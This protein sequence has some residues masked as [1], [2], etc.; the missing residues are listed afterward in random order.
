MLATA[1]DT[2]D[3]A[4]DLGRAGKRDERGHRVLDKGVTD[5]GTG[6][7]HHAQRPGWQA[8]LFEDARQQQA[9]ADRGVAGRLDHHGIAQGQGRCQGTG[10]QVQGEVPRADHPDHPQWLA[11]HPAFL[12]GNVG[13]DNAPVDAAGQ[14]CRLQGDG[15]GG[16]PFD[17]GLDPGAAG[18]ADDPVDDFLTTFIEDAHGLEHHLAACG[19]GLCGPVRLDLAGAAVRRIEVVAVGHGNLQ[20]GLLVER[21][22]YRQRALG[23]ASTPV[24]GQRLQVKVLVGRAGRGHRFLSYCV[25]KVSMNSP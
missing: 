13:A 14:A 15:A 10:G 17:L 1:G 20:Q 6:T 8:G 7:H 2:T 25:E 19:R 23:A 3:V 18:L 24:S 9:A 11:V 16:A 12:A 22:D 5:L 21:V 4:P